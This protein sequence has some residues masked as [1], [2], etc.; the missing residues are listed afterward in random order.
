MFIENL[1]RLDPE[2]DELR[3]QLE[4]MQADDASVGTLRDT[5]KAYAAVKRTRKTGG[6]GN[7]TDSLQGLVQFKPPTMSR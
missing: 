2:R 5:V 3:D 1:A 7:I 4:L 6:R